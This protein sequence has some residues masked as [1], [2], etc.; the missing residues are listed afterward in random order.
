MKGCTLFPADDLGH[1]GESG[2]QSA[3]FAVPFLRENVNPF[4]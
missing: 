3:G 2:F 4:S 1:K